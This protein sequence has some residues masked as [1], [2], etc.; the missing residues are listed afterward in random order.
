[1]TKSNA[2]IVFL[3]AL[4]GG[5]AVALFA[6]PVGQLAASK[7]ERLGGKTSTETAFMPQRFGVPG[8]AP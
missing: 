3:S 6:H 5:L 7:T 1:M 4:A 2:V 8:S